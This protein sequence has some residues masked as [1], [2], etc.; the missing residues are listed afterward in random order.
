MTLATHEQPLPNAAPGAEPTPGLTPELAQKYA[1]L[2]QIL[3]EM[4]ELVIGY[5]GGVDSTLVMKVAHDVLGAKAVA[6]TG[7][8]EAFSQ[9]EVDAALTVAAE[10]AV[11]VTRVRT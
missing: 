2:R 3:D 11:D 5:S 4:G 6:V 10:M 9:G 7:D 1:R 8:S